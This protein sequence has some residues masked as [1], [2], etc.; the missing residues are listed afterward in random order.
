MPTT[1]AQMHGKTHKVFDTA[2]LTDIWV[3][4]GGEF[5]LNCHFSSGPPNCIIIIVITAIII[6]IMFFAAT[7][8][9]R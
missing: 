7:A 5:T 2:N 6:V 8:L 4:V 9:L 3:V 1:H